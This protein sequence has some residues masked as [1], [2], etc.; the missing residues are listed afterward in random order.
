MSKV[1]CPIQDLT[2]NSAYYDNMHL[3]QRIKKYLRETV[4]E[5][6]PCLKSPR[7][8]SLAASG[9]NRNRLVKI[10]FGYLIEQSKIHTIAADSNLKPYI[11]QYNG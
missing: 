4:S 2:C 3:K 9:L 1:R 11:S 8:A 10:I 5:A 6:L 7:Y